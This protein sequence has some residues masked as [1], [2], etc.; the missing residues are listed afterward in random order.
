MWDSSVLD[1]DTKLQLYESAVVS[2]LVY[3]CEGWWLIEQLLRSVNGW[4]SRCL[5]RITGRTYRE[6]AVTPSYNLG[7]RIRSRR[8]RWLGHV[9]REEETHLVRRVLL[10]Y[11]QDKLDT[12]GYPAGSILMDAPHH[13][14]TEGLVELAK[15][16]EDWNIEVNALKLSSAVNQ[17][18]RNIEQNEHK[19]K[20]KRTNNA[21]N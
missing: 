21:M 18:K 12:G 7:N 5:S 10:A 11:M 1:L 8:L 3:G 19:A 2:V 17:K 20:R 16:K 15:D 13:N 4:N 14:T 9:L 6:E